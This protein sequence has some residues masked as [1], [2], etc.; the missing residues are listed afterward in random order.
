MSR[1]ISS[2]GWLSPAAFRVSD[3]TKY[4]GLSRTTIYVLIKRGLLASNKVGGR[5]LILRE[6]LDALVKGGANV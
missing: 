2:S 4:S 1:A 3:A 6:S 5:R